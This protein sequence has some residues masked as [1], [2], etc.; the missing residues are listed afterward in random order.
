MARGRKPELD[1]VIPMT[2]GDGLSHDE[3]NSREAERLAPDNLTDAQRAVWDRVAPELNGL[4]RLKPHYVDVVAEY[5]RAMARMMEL[6]GDLAKHGET[7]TV[8]GRNGVQYKTRP[9]VA[10]LNE[11]WRQWRSIVGMLG[12]SPA[13]ER[14]LAAGQGDLFDNPFAGIARMDGG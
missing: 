13:D 14:G 12:L 8:S 10:Q 5:C 7:Y 11:A 3:R 2:Q 4:G 1:N 6:R 9:E